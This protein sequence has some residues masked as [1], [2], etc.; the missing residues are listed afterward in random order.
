M[1]ME[2]FKVEKACSVASLDRKELFFSRVVKGE[3]I[4]P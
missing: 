3:I 1:H 2:S 4:F